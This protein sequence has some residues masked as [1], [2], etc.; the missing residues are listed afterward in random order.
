MDVVIFVLNLQLKE[1]SFVWQ[2][3]CFSFNCECGVWFKTNKHKAHHMQSVHLKVIP[4]FDINTYII[5]LL[6]V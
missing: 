4:T 6:L 1:N 3:F 2:Y 5:N